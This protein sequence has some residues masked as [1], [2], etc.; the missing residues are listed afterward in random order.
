MDQVSEEKSEGS[1][2]GECDL[3]RRLVQCADLVGGPGALSQETGIPRSTL[4]TYLAGS[5]EPKASRLEAIARA[6]KVSGHWLLTGDG[7]RALGDVGLNDEF[8]L[9]PRYDVRAAGGAGALVQSEQVVDHLAFKRAWLR[10]QGLNASK[11]ALIEATGDSM[12]PTIATGDLVLVALDQAGVSD[13]VYVIRRGNSLIVKRLQ[14]LQTGELQ[15]ISDN[16]AYAS[17]TIALDS[18]PNVQILGRVRWVGRNFTGR[19]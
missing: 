2:N 14:L 17:E 15:I 5:A 12:L 9:V 4:D 16:P 10:Q 13:G 11:L 6:A 3:A 8:A 7:P 19:W 1:T 18:V